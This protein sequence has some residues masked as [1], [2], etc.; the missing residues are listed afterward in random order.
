MISHDYCSLEA[1]KRDQAGLVTDNS[2]Y[3]MC[4][5][6]SR[7]VIADRSE[8]CLTNFQPEIISVHHLIDK[9]FLAVL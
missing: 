1:V 8:K 6:I 3:P 9:D 7:V 5:S 2:Q 4:A